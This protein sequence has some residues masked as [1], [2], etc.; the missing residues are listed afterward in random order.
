MELQ[1]LF[2]RESAADPFFIIIKGIIPS[3]VPKLIMAHPLF[4]YQD[5]NLAVWKAGSKGIVGLNMAV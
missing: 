4:R 3:S 1:T 5:P 2:K